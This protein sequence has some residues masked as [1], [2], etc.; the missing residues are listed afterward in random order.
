MTMIVLDWVYLWDYYQ[1]GV[2]TL[3]VPFKS[4]SVIL[5]GAYPAYWNFL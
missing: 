3:A 5:K 4:V 1:L 2:H